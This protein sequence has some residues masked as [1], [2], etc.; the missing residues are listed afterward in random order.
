MDD[1]LFDYYILI[2]YV[3]TAHFLS[4]KIFECSLSLTLSL[5]DYTSINSM[6]YFFVIFDLTKNTALIYFRK[7]GW[8][9]IPHR[10]YNNSCSSIESIMYVMHISE[11]IFVG[12]TL[13]DKTKYRNFFCM[14]KENSREAHHLNCFGILYCD[15]KI[16]FSYFRLT[17]R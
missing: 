10:N 15:S 12:E 1:T 5:L 4:A 16:W 6:F 13:D 11:N 14:M 7:I 3:W 2:T 9:Q 17:F 8:A